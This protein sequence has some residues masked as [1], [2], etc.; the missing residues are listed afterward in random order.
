MTLGEALPE[1]MKRVRGIMAVYQSLSNGA[2]LI[3]AQMME[4]SLQRADQA[5][6]SGDCIEMMRCYEDLK[7]YDL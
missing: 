4:M 6:I 7:G 2:G 3:A 5:V 1:E